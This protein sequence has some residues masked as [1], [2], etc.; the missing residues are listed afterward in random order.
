[1]P[2]CQ[3]FHPIDKN[4]SFQVKFSVKKEEIFATQAITQERDSFSSRLAFIVSAAGS[5]I[6]L[7]NIWKFPY[8]VGQYGGGSFILLYLLF[9]VLVGIPAF[10]SEIIIGKT[11]HKP[12]SAAFEQLGKGSVGWKRIGAIAS[13]TGFIVSS[14]YSVV[15]GWILGYFTQALLGNLAQI[16][17]I[18]AAHIHFQSLIQNPLWA[19]AFQLLFMALSVW[20]LLGGCRRGIEVCNKV[21]MPLFFLLLFIFTG[22]ASSLP[23]ASEIVSFFTSFSVKNI[24]A[25]AV[26]IALGHAFF[27]LSIGQGTLITYGSYLHRQEKTLLSSLAVVAADTLVSLLSAFCILSVVFASHKEMNF[28][29]SLIFETLPTIFSHSH[30]GTCIVAFFFFF[31]FIAALTSQVSALEPLI[32]H[33]NITKGIE[34]KKATCMVCLGSFLLGIPSALS[35]SLLQD[36]TFFGH[37]FLDSISFITTSILIPVCGCAAVL[38]VGWRWGMKAALQQL[39]VHAPLLRFY[40]ITTIKYLAP[41]LIILVFLHVVGAWNG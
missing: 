20:F 9:L 13:W 16:D 40:F 31:V 15:A 8:I 19:P 29:P 32:A 17:T 24:S 1:V 3:L 30:F 22:W 23:T 21:C 25:V 6:G 39:Q 33:L 34:R 26:I 28:G 35:T 10:I 36:M 12:P 27:T 41:I 11:T 18:A 14:F 5:A 37:N 4:F 7:A 2:F 38:L